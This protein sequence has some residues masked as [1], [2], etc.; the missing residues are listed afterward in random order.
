MTEV[1]LTFGQVAAEYDRWRPGY[2]PEVFD[3]IA[4]R[5]RG[6]RAL[7]IGAGTAKATAEL[8]RTG[9]RV[10]AVEPDEAMA[11]IGRT[12]EP[13]AVWEVADAET[14]DPQGRRFDLVCGAQSWHWVPDAADAVLASVLDPGGAM[15]W[16]WNHPDRTVEE[17]LFADLYARYM[18]DAAFS[19][20]MA[21]HRRDEDFWTDRLARVAARVEVRTVA[22]NRPM[23]AADYIAL[24]GTYSDHI[25]LPAGR[26]SDLLGAIHARLMAEDGTI[27]LGY[28]T[29][30]FLGFV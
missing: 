22:W 8:V 20:R 15:A 10:T 30:A 6:R 14:W 11:A 7:E 21:M 1:G 5:V 16:V 12:K 25:N 4:D 26:R 9:F 29:R 19:A 3:W 28:V 23:P 13:E 27:T 18:P 2:P 17:G 24:L